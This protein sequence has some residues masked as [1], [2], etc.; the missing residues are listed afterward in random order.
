MRSSYME[1]NY[2][3][4]LKA[5]V[6]AHK[7]KI[8]VECGVL[9]GYSTFNIAEAIKYNSQRTGIEGE[10][11]AFDLWDD[12]EYKHGSFEEVKNMLRNK[13][14]RD[15][16]YLNKGNAFSVY[17]SFDNNS[18][19]FIHI[20]ISN[21]GEILLDILSLWGSKLS[22]NGIIVFEGG[23]IDRDNVEWMKNYMFTPINSILKSSMISNNWDYKILE[24]F[25]SMSILW[26]K[27]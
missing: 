16:C 1:N 18:I 4:V 14:L 20:D 7:P 17:K 13:G 21:N 27:K 9:D 12:Y 11:F 19:D 23:S 25:P 26:K 2:G 8:S 15:Y 10:F 22:D 5:L 6:F 3:S 24:P